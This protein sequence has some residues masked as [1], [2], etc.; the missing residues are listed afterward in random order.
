[1]ALIFRQS[2]RAGVLSPSAGL[3]AAAKTPRPPG[4]C[5]SN[6]TWVP[7]SS[8]P[9]LVLHRQG[10]QKATFKAQTSISG[11]D[12]VPLYFKA[13]CNPSPVCH[14]TLSLSSSTLEKTTPSLL[15]IFLWETISQA[16]LGSLLN[17]FYHSRCL[18]QTRGMD[19]SSPTQKKNV[20][21]R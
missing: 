5:F 21:D 10:P 3:S 11:L 14:R 13:R 16:V 2:H 9:Q 17:L 7:Q 4:S 8:R 15:L 12:N 6:P 20:L 19:S 18:L 1:M